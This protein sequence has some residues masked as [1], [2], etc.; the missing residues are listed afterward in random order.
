MSY[1]HTDNWILDPE[2]YGN[3]QAYCRIMNFFCIASPMPRKSLRG[4]ALQNQTWY[5]N[6]ASL[7]V[8]DKAKHVTARSKKKHLTEKVVQAMLRKGER[9][10]IAFFPFSQHSLSSLPEFLQEYH[11]TNE[12]FLAP[13]TSP[14][15]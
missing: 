1:V 6:A 13:F 4:C 12:D 7:T 14:E 2:E 8:A 10:E 3:K 5:Q 11:L 15:R 9:E